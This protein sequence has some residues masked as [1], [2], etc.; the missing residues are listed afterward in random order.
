MSGFLLPGLVLAAIFWLTGAIC[1]AVA[2]L[3]LAVLA[4]WR[5]V[6]RWSWR[7]AGRIVVGSALWPMLLWRKS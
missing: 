3:A 6:G 5:G 4:A 1:T 2:M 7:V